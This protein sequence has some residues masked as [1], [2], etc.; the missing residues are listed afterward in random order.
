[1]VKFI[2]KNILLLFLLTAA[3]NAQDFKV[4]ASVDTTDY[5]VG[6]YIQLKYRVSHDENI[7]YQMPS[8]QD[9]LKDILTFIRE[10]PAG[11]YDK[12]NEI[13]EE[14]TYLFSVYDST[15]VLVPSIRF[16]YQ[17]A[18]G[19]NRHTYSNEV[20]FTV[21]TIEVNTQEDIQDVKKPL[22]IPLNWQTILLIAL[23]VI[24]ILTI[25]YMVYRYYIK[26]KEAKLGL[27]P[28]IKIP[29]HEIAL[30]SLRSLEEQKLWQQGK[31]KEYHSTLTEII[32]RYFEA[33][34]NFFAMEMPSSEVLDYLEKIK[35]GRKI[36]ETA[37]SFFSNAD[38]VKFA[39]FQ[40][41]PSVNEE[42]MKQAY[43]IVKD[44][45]EEPE[46]EP[47]EQKSGVNNAE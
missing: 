6:D 25:L 27:Q 29:P 30:K 3:V 22:R 28:E 4:K 19:D 16:D 31:V 15:D 46:T 34:F 21:H 20:A 13:I 42:M 17:T 40:P 14:H 41:I 9:S 12:D 5:L 18:E 11:N 35:D 44:T 2:F 45:V 43:S 7:K 1:M 38:L 10:L 32:R 26:K 47:A 36:K 24:V 23:A 37:A 39:K 8:V 33:R